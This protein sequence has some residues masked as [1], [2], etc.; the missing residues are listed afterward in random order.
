M[1]LYKLNKVLHRD[2]GYLFVGMIIVYALSG[3]AINHRKDWNPNYVI[4]KKE[5]KYETQI[6]KQ[7]INKEQILDILDMS[8]EASSYKNHYFPDDESLRIFIDGG[9]VLVDLSNGDCFLETN[10]KRALFYEVNFL[11]YNPGVLWTWFSDFF[12][13]VLIFLGIG[14]LFI[15]KGKNGLKWR[16]AILTSIGVIVPLIFL[17][18]YL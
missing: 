3:I 10:R 8:G 4:E 13:V 12:C 16:G 6:S 7:T 17:L 1:N 15:V 11:H 14:G 5:F 2:L 18:Y 9:N